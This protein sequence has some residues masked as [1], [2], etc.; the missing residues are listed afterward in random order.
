MRKRVISILLILCISI[1]FVYADDIQVDVQGSGTH[2]GG[3][4]T[5]TFDKKYEGWIMFDKDA[6]R[7]SMRS[8]IAPFER[9]GRTVDLY[10][11]EAQ[12]NFV[13]SHVNIWF[14]GHDK[15]EITC[16]KC[17]CETADEYLDVWG[18]ADIH[19]DGSFIGE[20]LAYV[21]P[22]LKDDEGQVYMQLPQILSKDENYSNVDDKTRI[23]RI[24]QYFS[25]RMVCGDICKI[26]EVTE[27]EWE[28]NDYYMVV[29][30]LG[31]FYKKFGTGVDYYF[32]A[33]AAEVAEMYKF[34]YNSNGYKLEPYCAKGLTPS[35]PG[36]ACVDLPRCI[37]TNGV[38]APSESE[39]LVKK[40]YFDGV[41][42]RDKDFQKTLWT[43]SNMIRR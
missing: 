38:E 24:Y 19:W 35:C 14:G 30:A 32:V 10:Q 1:N 23:K 12:V 41:M 21:A 3:G 28:S 8:K 20:P 29:E 22:Q 7:V 18:N 31:V 9:I 42:M 27:E 16:K 2:Y 26:M 6:V 13:Q 11:T 15:F 5:W 33:T 43:R 17:D 36:S 4:G 39:G 25:N 37:Y 34:N 40:G